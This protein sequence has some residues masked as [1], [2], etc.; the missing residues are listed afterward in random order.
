MSPTNSLQANYGD[1]KPM[2]PS[3]LTKIAMMKIKSVHSNFW[4]KRKFG[5]Q[6]YPNTNQSNRIAMKDLGIKLLLPTLSGIQ[7]RRG[8]RD[9]GGE[10]R[11]TEEAKVGGGEEVRS[12]LC[13]E[14]KRH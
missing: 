13:P 1:G 5:N 3:L 7:W 8:G 14:I 10:R 9:D 12:E 11:R 2:K 4:G 6:R